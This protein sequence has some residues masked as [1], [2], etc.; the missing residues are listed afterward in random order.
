MRLTKFHPDIIVV[1]AFRIL[2]RDV[3]TK[4]KL[5]AFN[6]HGSLLPKYRGA[7]PINW[8]IMNGDRK[9]GITTFFLEDKVDTGSM[10]YQKE[11]DINENDS[12]GDIHDRLSELGSALVLR[13][14]E[15]I[16][17]G[18]APRIIQNS[19]ESSPAPKIFK[20]HCR[21]SWDKSAEQIHNQIRGLSPYPAAYTGY[22]NKIV[23]I[24]KTI[25]TDKNIRCQTR[26]NNSH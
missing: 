14:V 16:L 25:K 6:L 21:I 19:T 8:V 15:S 12:A 20:E 2:P 10:I 17:K 3:Y 4:A 1:V 7:A 5:G 24:Y 26:L 18:D 11:I 13:T 9:T 22:N 23:K